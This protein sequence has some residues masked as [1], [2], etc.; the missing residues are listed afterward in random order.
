VRDVGAEA[1]AYRDRLLAGAETDVGV[2]AEDEESARRPLA[3]LDQT[4]IA[5][6]GRDRLVAPRGEG[7]R[8]R[9]EDPIAL[10]FGDL[11]EP[12]DLSAEILTHV[13]RRRAHI[14]D[15]F[16]GALKQFVLVSAG[17]IEVGQDLRRGRVGSQS[18]GLVND[19]HLDLNAER[20][21]V[22]PVEDD[23]HP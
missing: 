3:V 5:R 20:W 9:A 14:G 13:L 17:I 12:L 15:H 18:T 16:D 6:I 22:G 8:S 4:V 10:P 1:V 2:D 23:I 19:L 21:P 11:D 7:V